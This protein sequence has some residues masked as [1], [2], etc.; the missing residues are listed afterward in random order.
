[1]FGDPRFHLDHRLTFGRR[2]PILWKPKGVMIIE[3]IML[4]LAL[5]ALV[6]RGSGGQNVTLVDGE[7]DVARRLGNRV[8]HRRP[9]NRLK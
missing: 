5:T 7:I 4:F 1:M 9:M 8:R 3:I 6:E 2:K